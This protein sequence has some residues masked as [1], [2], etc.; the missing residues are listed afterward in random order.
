MPKNLDFDGFQIARSRSSEGVT[1]TDLGCDQVLIG[2]F[3][4]LTWISE[5]MVDFQIFDLNFQIDRSRRL[6]GVERADLIHGM[7]CFQI[8]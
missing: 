2:N 4:N 8:L 6:E 5:N 7:L 1:S 3:E